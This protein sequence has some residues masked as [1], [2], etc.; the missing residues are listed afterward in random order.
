[1][2]GQQIKIGYMGKVIVHDKYFDKAEAAKTAA[3]SG[4][5]GGGDDDDDDEEE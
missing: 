3:A 4:G 5:G 2:G 1:M